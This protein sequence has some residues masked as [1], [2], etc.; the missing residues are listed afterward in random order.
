[1]AFDVG[2]KCALKKLSAAA[3]LLV[4]L[5]S[6][7]NGPFH[8]DYCRVNARRLNAYSV[9]DHIGGKMLFVQLIDGGSKL[10]RAQQNPIR[11]HNG[12]GRLS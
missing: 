10:V 8:L 5:H 12:P 7:T 4:C 1:M 6:P 9:N 11:K 2:Q 3:E